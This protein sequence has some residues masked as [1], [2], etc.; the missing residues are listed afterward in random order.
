MN[1]GTARMVLVVLALFG[2]AVTYH[3]QAA[4]T[5]GGN[6]AAIQVSNADFGPAASLAL[7]E[8]NREAQTR[9]MKGVAVVVFI[10]GDKTVSWF[11]QMQVVGTMILGNSNVLAVAYSK[12]SEMAD[13]LQD[14]GSGVRKPYRGEFGYKGGTIQ[15]IPSGYLLAAFSGGK[16]T[17]DLAVAKVGLAEL[18]KGM[19]AS[20]K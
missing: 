17:D 5:P 19:Q 11:S 14:S 18:A 1:S 7:Q 10:P 20:P 9:K 3:A 8:M 16:D 6:N 12:I 13:T 2:L 4:D 15:K